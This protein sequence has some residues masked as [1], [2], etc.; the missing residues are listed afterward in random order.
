MRHIF[1]NIIK[2]KVIFLSDLNKKI[3]CIVS[4]NSA[5]K[6]REQ[7][8]NKIIS[9]GSIMYLDMNKNKIKNNFIK[10]MNI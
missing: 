10:K 8:G 6:I 3:N 7:I 1:V 2:K 4:N 9:P 5:D